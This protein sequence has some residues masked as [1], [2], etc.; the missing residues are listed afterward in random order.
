MKNTERNKVV[1][2]FIEMKQDWSRVVNAYL[3]AGSKGVYY[4]IRS[5]CIYVK[6]FHTKRKIFK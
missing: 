2:W 1:S 4:T 3:V 5:S 6:I